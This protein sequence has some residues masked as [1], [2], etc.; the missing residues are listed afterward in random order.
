MEGEV[1]PAS[2]GNVAAQEKAP[3]A[4]PLFKKEVSDLVMPALGEGIHEGLKRFIKV[5]RVNVK[6]GSK[7]ENPAEDFI[8]RLLSDD[9]SPLFDESL[10]KLLE[11]DLR[12]QAIIIDILYAGGDPKQVQGF[13]R[14][15]G[16]GCLLMFLDARRPEVIK[17]IREIRGDD[18]VKKKS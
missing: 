4:K 15:I 7:S 6:P 18:L 10:W 9:P 11:S 13:C 14:I 16:M 5:N 1:Q 3:E 8:R 17:A 2:A 12:D